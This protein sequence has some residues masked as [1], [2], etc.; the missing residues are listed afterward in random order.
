MKTYFFSVRQGD[1]SRN[2]PSFF[3]N[4]VDISSVQV[5]VFIFHS[6]FYSFHFRQTVLHSK[7]LNTLIQVIDGLEELSVSEL[8]YQPETM[9][10]RANRLLT[11]DF[12]S[13][14]NLSLSK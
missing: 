1:I 9:R 2:E 8:G 6:E 10:R 11:E 13:Y 14:E 5:R 12:S 7:S 3:T 4:T